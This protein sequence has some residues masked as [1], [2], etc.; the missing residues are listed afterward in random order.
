MKNLYFLLFLLVSIFGFAQC[1]TSPIT[2]NS[3]AN[4][5]AFETNYPG[6]TDLDFDLFISGVD[7]VDLT[8]LSGITS[9]KGFNISNTSL[10]NLSGFETI[11]ESVGQSFFTISN[12]D[13]L[14]DISALSNLTSINGLDTMEISNNPLL[15]NLEGLEGVTDLLDF[16]IFNNDALEN[17][18]G[19]SSV[20][21]VSVL[22]LR[23]NLNLL[24][25]NGL[26]SVNTIESL[27]IENNSVLN[28]IYS[29]NDLGTINFFGIDIINNPNL[30]NCDIDS[31]CEAISNLNVEFS[32]SGNGIG[33]ED[34]ETV[35]EQCIGCP[36]DQ[37]SLT[38]QAEVDAFDIQYP[39]CT[40]LD[41]DLIISGND[42]TDLTPLSNIV[43]VHS[44][45][46]ENNPQLINLN[47]LNSIIHIDGYDDD[48]FEFLEI[49]NNPQLQSISALS[50]MT[51]NSL[52]EG[53]VIR[54]NAQLTSLNGLQAF[55]Q[56]YAVII[57]NND[58][59]IDLVGLENVTDTDDF[60]I[61][62]NDNLIN[63]NGLD[64]YSFGDIQI[65]NN[66]SLQNVVGLTS[67]FQG[68]LELTGNSSLQSLQGLEQASSIYGIT[69]DGNN[70]LSDISAINAFTTES[71]FGFPFVIKNNLML[72]TCSIDAVCS[73]LTL[74]NS[75]DCSEFVIENNAPGCNSISEVAFECSLSPSNDNCETAI[76]LENGQSVQ[77]YNTFG[78]QS[79]EVPSCNDS[80]NRVDV[81]FTFNSGDNTIFD[82][83]VEN[84]SYNLQ[85]W[86]GNCT[87]LTQVSNACASN[88]LELVEVNTNT[89]YYLQV[90]SDIISDRGSTFF[91]ITIYG[92]TLSIDDVV[93]SNFSIYPNPVKDV[94]EFKSD[95]TVNKLEVYNL[96]GQ[97][98]M[99]QFPNQ[100]VGKLDVS[101]LSSG[102]YII[103]IG[104]DTVY[105][106]HRIIKE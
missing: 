48:N 3:Q 8:P 43:S 88:I 29:L 6:C 20:S 87:N 15:E 12:N 81:W 57:D 90:W 4:V 38:S 9:I 91:D 22:I 101:S 62:N 10:V 34:Y 105:E 60:L 58:L 35:F 59:L 103:K 73:L 21:T 1:P 33:C 93:E 84:G 30:S 63:L 102:L 95:K 51:S 74:C 61:S 44:L 40:E 80:E 71:G 11:V 32:I 92:V 41:Y 99:R 98:V 86:E 31:F 75:N 79:T 64:S 82:I 5:D 96:L 42:I 26:S 16:F 104:S 50:N 49:S 89:D 100:S 56:V 65:E 13:L 78:T 45:R 47:G 23:D 18:N 27:L 36:L 25:L 46:I 53:F 66:S 39:D 17:L 2:L 19:L 37:V 24:N 14:T 52:I 106:L 67:A 28:N 76:V 69:L 68:L 70:V 54:N 7:I 83:L 94:L 85:L 55:N 72:S 97:N 77:A